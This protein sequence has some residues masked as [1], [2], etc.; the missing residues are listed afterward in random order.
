VI[1][2]NGGFLRVTNMQLKAAVDALQKQASKL[3]VSS[4]FFPSAPSN[5]NKPLS[6]TN[7][8]ESTLMI[9]LDLKKSRGSFEKNSPCFG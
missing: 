1:F 9:L 4:T 3:R 5:I 2:R 8:V 7:L 6:K